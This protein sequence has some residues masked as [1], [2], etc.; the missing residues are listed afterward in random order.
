MGYSKDIVSGISW[1]GSLSIL[2]KLIGLL[3]ILII[4]KLLL[5][6]Q[7]GAYGVALLILGILEVLTETGV[8]VFLLQEKKINHYISSAWIVSILRGIF[9]TLILIAIAP[10][11]SDFFHSRESQFLIYLIGAV[12]FLR[13]FINPAIVK[14]QKELFFIKD[15]WF[16]FIVLVVDTTVAISLTYVLRTPVGIIIGL[17]AGVLTE[18]ILSFIIVSP[19]PGLD[20]KFSYITKIFHRGKWIT[21]SGTFDYVFHNIDNI[22][23]GRILGPAALG[24]YQLAY[25]VSVMP[26]TEIGKVFTHVTLPVFVK[27]HTSPLKLKTAF[28]RIFI[29]T[30]L[31]S[32]PITLVLI[33]F[34]EILVIILGMK[35]S[36]VGPILPVLAIVG[37]LK[38]LSG[39]T[40]GLFLSQKKQKCSTIVTFV[41]A[42]TLCALIIPLITVGGLFGAGLAGLSSMV[43]A[44]PFLIYY[45]YKIFSTPVNKI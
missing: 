10:L 34:P 42:L 44:I 26:M 38:A 25:S 22:A 27:M 40:T 7:F 8:N 20:F 1:M 6:A 17:I 23:V 28:L 32:V 12:A 15:F 36:A 14:F 18:L 24:I 29:I 3:E 45:V 30:L 37:F 31:I 35:W 43:I 19:R 39:T 13:G 16:R 9:I 5:P 33:F 41:N 4:A 11:V 21:A 2:T